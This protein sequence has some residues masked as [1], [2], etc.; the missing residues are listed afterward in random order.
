MKNALLAAVATL[1]L[2]GPAQAQFIVHDPASNLARVLE[3]GR[4]L[5]QMVQQYQML[6]SQYEATARMLGSGN[7]SSMIGALGSGYLP[8]ASTVQGIMSGQGTYGSAGA[9]LEQNR[10]YQSRIQDE[11]AIEMQRREEITA[12]ARALVQTGQEEA[13]REI[14]TL[15]AL[16]AQVNNTTTMVDAE[17][18]NAEIAA[19]RHRQAL[20]AQRLA[21]VRTLLASADR[22]DRLRDEQWTRR[23]AQRWQEYLGGGGTATARTAPTQSFGFVGY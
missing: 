4:S 22:T 19:I 18:L 20:H 15:G 9:L 23:D 13:E 7:V 2:A 14:A 21:D 12:N 11:R 3:A 16:Q 8:G 10:L 1:A 17:L 6:K 5:A